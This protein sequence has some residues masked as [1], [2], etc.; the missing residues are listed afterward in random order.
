MQNGIAQIRLFDSCHF[1]WSES[2]PAD[3][4]TQERCRFSSCNTWKAFD[5]H[6]QG[7]INLNDL[8]HF[9]LDEADQMLDMG[10]IHDIRKLLKI[11]PPKRQS[12]FFS[13][14]MPKDI[15]SLSGQILQASYKQVRIAIEKPTA[16]RVSQAVYYVAKKRETI[17]TIGVTEDYE[18]LRTCVW[19]NK[20]RLRQNS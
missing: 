8:T 4:P 10:F 6:S 12:L 13:A 2:K 20:A 11:I 18:R 16:D 3:R 14:T 19:P 9:V 1:W 7:Y 5:L 15:I 17:H